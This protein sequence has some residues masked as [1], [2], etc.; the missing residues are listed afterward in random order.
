[1]TTISDI[2]KQA[3][4]S[5]TLVSRVLNNKPGVSPENRE[6]I[7]NI[8][9]ETHYIPSGLARSL[10]M[11][12]TNAIGVVMDELCNQFFFKLIAGLQ[13]KGEELGYHVLFC[14]SQ[15]QNDTKMKYV[16]YFAQGRADGIISYG[17]NLDNTGLFRYIADLPVPCVFIEGGPDDQRASCIRIDNHLGAYRAAEHLILQGRKKL[18]HVTGDM[19]YT[20]S[21]DRFNGFVHAMQDYH[22]SITADSIIYADFFEESAYQQMKQ[23]IAAGS[24]PDAVFAGAD[25]T[26]YGVLRA[27]MEAGISVPEDVAVIG[28]DD[29][30]PDSRDILFPGL[31]TMRQPLYEMGQAAIELL[32]SAIENPKAESETRT[33]EPELILRDTCK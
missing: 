4:V 22:I 20:A 33:F 27:L 5:R 25:K 6:K 7:L 18:L 19:N 3:N 24:L 31:S 17:S 9:K 28:F 13:D 1:M 21:L 15:K 8:M 11:Q 2:A 10:V 12:K 32:V 23:R 16:D 26:A 30:T 29:D 14:G